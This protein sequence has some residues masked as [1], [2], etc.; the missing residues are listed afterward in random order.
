MP[1][2]EATSFLRANA[3]LLA[4]V[5]AGALLR[6][7]YLA[8]LRH[9]PDFASPTADAAFHDYWARGIVSGEWT[10][11]AG[12]PDPKVT[13]VPFLRPPGYPYFLALAYAVTGSSYTGARVVQMALGLA[14]VVLAFALARAL[15][16][17][18]AGFIAAAL[19]AANWSLIYFEGELQDNVLLVTL[20][21]VLALAAARWAR[22]PSW[23]W[24]LAIGLA[25]GATALVRP[26]ILAFIPV[27]LVWAW[28]VLRRR[29]RTRELLVTAGALLLGAAAA[30]AP[31][32]IRNALVAGDPVLI[33]CNGAINLYIGN[34]PESDP[35]SPRIPDLRELAGTARWN[36]FAY[37]DL[38][39][40]VSRREGRTMSYSDVDR[41]FSKR[42]VDYITAHPARAIGLAVQ[43][44]LLMLG[45]REVSNNKVDHYE[46][47]N[48]RVLSLLPGFPVALALG[49][50]GALLV[51]T[52][53]RAPSSPRAASRARNVAS[54][55]PTREAQE[56]DRTPSS[57]ARDVRAVDRTPSQPSHAA[58]YEASLLLLL[59]AALYIFSYAPFLAAGRFRPPALPFLLVLGAFGI[60]RVW[61]AARD[62][63]G[64]RAAKWAGAFAAL[65]VL[66][67]IPFV[68]YTP[69]LAWWH[70]DRGAAYARIGDHAASAEEYRKVLEVKPD[71]I[72][73]LV[74]LGA[75]LAGQGR[76][77]EGVEYYQR[78]LEVAPGNA[79]VRA[80]YDAFL[81]AFGRGGGAS[82]TSLRT[83]EEYARA[84]QATPNDADAHFYL[85]LALAQE[86]KANEAIAAFGE[87]IRLQPEHAK[88]HQSLALTLKTQNRLDEAIAA[89]RRYLELEPS[90]A[91][92]LADLGA[93][94][95][96]K[97]ETDEAIALFRKALVVDANNF[98]AHVN[99]A[100]ALTSQGKVD[101]AI[102]HMRAAVR[103][104]PDNAQA[105]QWLAELE[106]NRSARP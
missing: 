27:L 47:K 56:R 87:A 82:G 12:E 63:D 53:S 104:Q 52:E 40:G 22:E 95:G 59:L 106:A 101:E 69:D 20:G 83:S 38:V 14:N 67:H 6:I 102:E 96:R 71:Y 30:I 72:D 66:A 29:A 77:D 94:L 58:R 11:P 105:K 93:M 86:G 44:T 13:S 99:M 92:S 97:G 62:R 9:A 78:A 31:A 33:S 35:V 25:A 84:V 57:S 80:K 91:N 43:R 1:R 23:R 39:R 8:E 28:W 37:G 61:Q 74:N 46:R 18:R 54:A 10:P 26:N 17:R 16:G 60:D 24:A 41:Y 2:A 4:I 3:P 85:G 7:A 34:N 50:L 75:A 103:A 45:P 76:V 32:T 42:A 21:L 5:A 51:V 49:L 73:A 89:Y 90:D 65:L 100:T 68:R 64:G 88:A 55:Q 15:Y 70:F 79:E 36:W 19:L 48:S 98:P 81:A